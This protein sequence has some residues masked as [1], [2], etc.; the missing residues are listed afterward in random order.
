MSADAS[1]SP[2]PTRSAFARATKRSTNSAYT[3]RC[4]ATRLAAVQ[5]CPVVPNPPQTAPSTARSSRASSITMMMFLPPISRWQ[6]LKAGAQ[7]SDTLRPTSVEPVNDTM[8]TS[9]SPMSG[10]PTCVPPPVTMLTTPL[11]RPASS[12]AWIR[13]T[14]E[15]GVS[16]AG[17]ITTVLPTMSAGIIFHEGMAI[18]KFHGVIS[19]AMPTGMRTDI[20]NL[21]DSSDGVV[22]PNW[23]RPSP[24][25]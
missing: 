2:L 7:A 13:F 22:C 20:W 15:S 4:T 11:G 19:P 10:A 24:A 18:G 21:L 12:R 16:D 23:R 6:C 9:L 8:W 1:T 3:F 14:T 5:R 25:M 17:L